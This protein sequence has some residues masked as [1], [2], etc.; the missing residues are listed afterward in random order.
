M[1]PMMRP[2]NLIAALVLASFAAMAPAQAQTRM[3]TCNAEWKA[4]KAANQTSGKTYHEFRKS[5]MMKSDTFVKAA[6]GS[7]DA[8]K[9]AKP[10]KARKSTPGREAATARQRACAAEWKADK[11]AGKVADGM[12]W[13][14]YWS[15]C[16]KRKKAASS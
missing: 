5:C 7:E 12:K 16:S 4:A 11:A 1:R 2:T 13:P 14:K 3:Q 8:A 6:T 9:A 10:K 15:D